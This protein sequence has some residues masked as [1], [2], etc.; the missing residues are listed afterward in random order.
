MLRSSASRATR[1]D[2]I[3]GL[4]ALPL[5]AAGVLGALLSVPMSV[6]L[7]LGAVPAGGGVG[8]ALLRGPRKTSG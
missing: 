5:V 1:T 7:G 2:A 3:L 8:Y 6:A 4:I